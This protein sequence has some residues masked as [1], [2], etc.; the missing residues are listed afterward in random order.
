MTA[1][2]ASC[3]ML[4]YTL[5]AGETP[6]FPGPRS[7]PAAARSQDRGLSRDLLFIGGRFCLKLSAMAEKFRISGGH[8]LNGRVTI[9]GA[10]NSALPCMAAALLTSE[11]VIL[12]NLPYVRDIIT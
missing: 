1:L 4:A 6:A 2:R 11:N 8:A 7:I 5:A 12:H 9:S 3:R 10:K